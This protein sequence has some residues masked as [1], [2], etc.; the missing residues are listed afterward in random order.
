MTLDSYCI[1]H[2]PEEKETLTLKPCWFF[3]PLRND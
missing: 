3:V 1:S 2:Y